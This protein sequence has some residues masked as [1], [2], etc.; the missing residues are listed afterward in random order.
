MSS[1]LL[2][3]WGFVMPAIVSKAQSTVKVEDKTREF[4]VLGEELPLAYR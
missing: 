4:L 2:E 3:G 1:I